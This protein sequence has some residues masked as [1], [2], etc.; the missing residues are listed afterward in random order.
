MAFLGGGANLFINTWT[1][2]G[3]ILIQ[4]VEI[5]NKGIRNEFIGKKE[6]NI[7]FD[8]PGPPQ[9]THTLKNTEL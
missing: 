8:H 2:T 9:D 5:K 4:T 3:V 1:V 7:I 6:K